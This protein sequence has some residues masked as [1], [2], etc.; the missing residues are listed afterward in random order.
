MSA[1]AE[2]ACDAPASGQLQRDAARYRSLVEASTSAV[3]A[4][5][6]NLGATEDSPSWRALTGQ[7]PLQMR[8]RGWLEA[9]HP[10]ERADARR[11]LTDLPT[12]GRPFSI[13]HRI[14]R[15]D[16]SYGTYL[17]RF[18][19]I[20]GAADDDE[21]EWICA[22]TDV[23]VAR[24]AE[25]H[26]DVLARESAAVVTRLQRLQWTTAAL[27]QATTVDEVAGVVLG[28]ASRLPGVV[29]GGLALLSP[30][31]RDLRFIALHDEPL[32]PGGGLPWCTIDAGADVPLA[33]VISTG[34]PL[35]FGEM[36]DFG[37]RFPHLLARQLAF[38]TRSFTA[39]PLA[40]ADDV[41]GGLMLQYDA[42]QSFSEPEQA[43]LAALGAQAAAAFTRAYEYEAQRGL[44]EML[45]R[46]L[47][48]ESL[49][50]LP[51][52]ALGAQY[53]PAGQGV[54]VGGDWFDVVPLDNGAVVVA[55]GDVM[56]K[57]V[58]AATVMGQV[59]AAL[60]SY[61]LLDPEPQVVL[62]R[63]DELVTTLGAPE[64]IVTLAYTLVS[65]DRTEVSIGVAGHIP[66]LVVP[67]AG[68]P[69]FV[70]LEPGAPLGVGEPAPDAVRL[71]LEPGTLLVLC[72]DGLVETRIHP[73]TAG[74][75]RLRLTL[76]ELAATEREPRELCE[77]LIA[78]L[79]EPDGEDDVAVLVL[80]SLGD[81]WLRTATVELPPDE[82]APRRAR[83]FLTARLALWQAEQDLVEIAE[84][85]LS[86]LVTNAIIHSRTAPRVALHLDEHRLLVLVTDQGRHGVARRTEAD[87]EDDSGR[88][89]A[90]VD[91]LA[92]AWDAERGPDG[93][94]VWFELERRR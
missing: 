73:I 67:P 61:A 38:D 33:E 43:F 19:P 63:L 91:A 42:Q 79:A 37:V 53:H 30:A 46:S 48:P 66:P 94:T 87:V 75:E 86:E 4:A 18:V 9:L 81:R 59:R 1:T 84:V 77:T 80:A 72:S 24:A 7:T 71:T 34:A 27:S 10:D 45:Q 25:R 83:R 13:E 60:R 35:F 89:L 15:A 5:D 92:T 8:G 36:A 85:C 20:D 23:T 49:P 47:L 78:Q 55:L 39:I 2:D 65:A 57:G 82:T 40:T 52:L 6:S 17:M 69:E 29:R 50:E 88:G 74:M 3:W 22:C 70:T 28:G 31:R 21:T 11:A 32:A 51:G 58:P 68:R 14:R 93:T 56:G 62:S 44:A 64:Q 76:D 54:D 16:A 12:R 26:R 90:L 41:I